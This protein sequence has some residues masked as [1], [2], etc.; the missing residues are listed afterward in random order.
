MPNL[1]INRSNLN[2]NFYINF[3]NP[4]N[5]VTYTSPEKTSK[6]QSFINDSIFYFGRN[7]YETLPSYFNLLEDVTFKGKIIYIKAS[8]DA[9]SIPVISNRKIDI[10]NGEWFSSTYNY[11]TP[12]FF[13]KSDA[14]KFIISYIKNKVSTNSLYDGYSFKQLTENT[15]DNLSSI[16]P[17]TSSVF[18]STYG[19]YYYSGRPGQLYEDHNDVSIS[20][21]RISKGNVKPCYVCEKSVFIN[22]SG[23]DSNEKITILIPITICNR[24]VYLNTDFPVNGVFKNSFSFNFAIDNNQIEPFVQYR[25]SQTP[26]IFNIFIN[27]RDSNSLYDLSLIPASS[28]SDE[29]LNVPKELWTEGTNP[30][31]Y[32]PETTTPGSGGQTN[33]DLPFGGDGG[34]LVFDYTGSEPIEDGSSATGTSLLSTSYAMNETEV[35]ELNKAFS[36][37]TLWLDFTSIFKDPQDGLINVLHFPFDVGAFDSSNITLKDPVSI[38]GVNLSGLPD[39][40]VTGYQMGRNFKT[41][42]DMGSLKIDTFF[43]SFLDF[44]PYTKIKIY[45]PF[46]GFLDITPTAIMGKTI[47]MFYNVNFADG[48]AMCIITADDVPVL[49]QNGTLGFQVPTSKSDGS[50]LLQAGIKSVLGSIAIGASGGALAPLIATAGVANGVDKMLSKSNTSISGTTQGL[51]A[52]A[53]SP[54]P[55]IIIERPYTNMPNGYKEIYGLATNINSILSSLSGFT[56]CKNVKLYNVTATEQEKS[57]IKQLLESGVIL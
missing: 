32:N 45:A 1:R 14:N 18:K 41:R 25:S 39:Y 4:N 47:H 34:E 21:P 51:H 13:T 40:N 42:I 37:K 11:T 56:K 2:G 17:I 3:N 33:P 10:L 19:D 30:I 31:P 49:I 16:T 44:D 50:D 43:N 53:L 5:L 6:I 48:S 15:T 20:N 23:I 55:F 46:F 29:Y 57:Q 26:S 54:I 27:S 38:L 36:S 28:V 7:G 52:R 9:I 8:D 24:E 12:T 35:Q 22:D